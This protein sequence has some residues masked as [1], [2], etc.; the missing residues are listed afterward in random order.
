MMWGN[1]GMGSW[2]WAFGTLVLV[3][4]VIL[5]IVLVRVFA[6]SRRRLPVST[7]GANSLSPKQILDE[8]YAK[9]ELTSEEYRERLATLG[10]MP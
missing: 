4:V 7:L 6:G 2:G 3:G 1:Y 5:V 8:R 10:L 9:G